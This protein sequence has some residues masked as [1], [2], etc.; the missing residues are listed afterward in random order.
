M[1]ES[2]IIGSWRLTLENR[3]W[4]VA[5]IF[6][7]PYRKSN[8]NDIHIVVK[9]YQHQAMHVYEA[10]ITVLFVTGGGS[11]GKLMPKH[12]YSSTGRKYT[13]FTPYKEI[14]S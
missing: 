13:G 2:S 1:L 6:F 10:Y 8:Y 7:F 14:E 4:S 11:V 9:S 3:S 5:T 12:T